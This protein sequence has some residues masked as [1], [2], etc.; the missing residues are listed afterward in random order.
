MWKSD[1]E[2]CGF[3]REEVHGL[4]HARQVEE[5]LHDSH[6]VAKKLHMEE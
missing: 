6:M 2:T 4:I 5:L 1:S 3:W